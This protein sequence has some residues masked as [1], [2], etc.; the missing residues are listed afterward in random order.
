MDWTQMRNTKISAEARELIDRA[1]AN[2]QVNQVRPAN[3]KGNEATRTTKELARHRGREF[4]R[5]Q[6][7]MRS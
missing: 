2:G 5:E 4:N 1:V 3:A 6:K 7:A